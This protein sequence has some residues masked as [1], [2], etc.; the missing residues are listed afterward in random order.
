MP[1]DRGTRATVGSLCKR[2]AFEQ[3][4]ANGLNESAA[5]NGQNFPASAV[6]T[7]ALV[8]CLHDLLHA[9][10][11]LMKALPKMAKAARSDNLTQAFEQHLLET[12]GQ[13]ERLNRVFDLLGLKAAA[14]PC[15]GMAGLIEEGQEIITQGK[16]QTDLSRGLS[17]HRGGP[18]G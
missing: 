7:E 17:P 4:R 13:I 2:P 18:K 9:E 1:A 5:A 12:Q 10:G 3:F 6:L 8:E 14:K 16:A 15:K 11:Q